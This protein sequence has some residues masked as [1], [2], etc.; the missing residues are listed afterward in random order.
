MREGAYERSSVRMFTIENRRL[1]AIELGRKPRTPLLACLSGPQ[2]PNAGVQRV[3]EFDWLFKVESTPEL[4]GNTWFVA[5]DS[6]E[7]GG[8]LTIRLP[9]IA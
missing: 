5:L 7:R 1:C 6:G 4:P 2:Q 9:E 3:P 8:N